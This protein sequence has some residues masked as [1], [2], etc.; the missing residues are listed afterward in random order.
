MNFAGMIGF[1]VWLIGCIDIKMNVIKKSPKNKAILVIKNTND[2]QSYQ[3][4]GL[5]WGISAIVA[6]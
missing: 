6:D 5:P 1:V 2:Q 3:M 4:D